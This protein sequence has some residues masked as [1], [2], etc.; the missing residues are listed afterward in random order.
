MDTEYVPF[1]LVT[2]NVGSVF[3]DVSALLILYFDSLTVPLSLSLSFSLILS[4]S[5][6]CLITVPFVEHDMPTHC[7]LRSRTHKHCVVS[8]VRWKTI[9]FYDSFSIFSRLFVCR[10]IEL[11]CSCC[12]TSSTTLMIKF[13]DVWEPFNASNN[14][15]CCLAVGC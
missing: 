10:P 14:L 4:H 13:D 1:L 12:C 8:V 9:E 11:E 5:H 15:M 2:A 6:I 3:E 7:L